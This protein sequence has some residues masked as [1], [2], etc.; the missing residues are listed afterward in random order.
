MDKLEQL[1]I[2]LNKNPNDDTFKVFM[3]ELTKYSDEYEKTHGYKPR[4]HIDQLLT[5]LSSEVI[6]KYRDKLPFSH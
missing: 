3:D 4:I 6:S 1:I 2:E 5:S